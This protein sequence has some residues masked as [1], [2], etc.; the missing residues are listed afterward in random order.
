MKLN[1]FI[2]L[3]LFLV[4]NL[5]IAQEK[6]DYQWV[7]GYPPSG[8]DSSLFGACL[9]DFNDD[10]LKFIKIPEA[11]LYTVR[12]VS[13]ICNKDGKLALYSNGCVLHNGEFNLVE[14]CNNINPGNV[15]DSY[16]DKEEPSYPTLNSQIILTVPEQ[17][18]Q[19]FYLTHR[20]DFSKKYYNDEYFTEF[21]HF[22][23]IDKSLNNGKGK[24]IINSDIEY[25][26][27]VHGYNLSVCKHANGKDWWIIN[28]SLNSK[29]FYRV[30]LTKDGISGPWEQD[31]GPPRKDNE[32]A[33]GQSV[34]SPDGKKYACIYS[35]SGHVWVFDFDRKTG[36]LS[37]KIDLDYQIKKDW[38]IRGVAISP[39][40]RYLYIAADYYMYQFDLFSPDIQ[41]SQILL[42]KNDGYNLP[43]WPFYVIFG[44]SQLAPD[45]KIY[46]GQFSGGCRQWSVINK[47]NEQG[48]TCDFKQHS[49]L[50]PVWSSPNVP[51]QPNFRLGPDTTTSIKQI[52]QYQAEMKSWYNPSSKIIKCW[53]QHLPT[54][55][56]FYTITINDITGRSLISKK[57]LNPQYQEDI[58]LDGSTLV[59][60]VYFVN[61]MDKSGLLVVGKVMVY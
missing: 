54:E 59:S 11:N 41:K 58:S 52:P 35:N 23:I 48:T 43:G 34:F 37:N 16:C 14:G 21:Y 29:K 7:I 20:I 57:V 4:G 44:S 56:D 8:G 19:Y 39:N 30:L 5:C 3:L 9:M 27:V 46:V 17:E 28:H 2:L 61:L 55:E 24:A 18:N 49:L 15:W 26:D 47:P 10:T 22:T 42:D 40:S 6:F 36:L 13:S 53:V 1:L 60:G 33:I 51:I 45:G 38:D 32:E 31:G 12:Q 25:P 50:L